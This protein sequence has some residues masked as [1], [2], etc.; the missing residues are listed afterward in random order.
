MIQGEGDFD[1]CPCQLWDDRGRPWNP[2]SRKINKDVIRSHNEVML[3]IGVAEPENG[4]SDSQIEASRQRH[5]YEEYHGRMLNIVSQH[6]EL[7]AM[8]GVNGLRHRIMVCPV[9][10]PMPKMLRL[11]VIQDLQALLRDTLLSAFQIPPDESVHTFLLADWSA[12]LA[13][14]LWPGASP[15]LHEQSSNCQGRSVRDVAPFSISIFS[16]H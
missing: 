3:V 7:L 8:Y 15:S 5:R 2:A 16:R 12:Q 6:L 10:H 14:Q 13:C 4:L 9:V 1:P 11:T